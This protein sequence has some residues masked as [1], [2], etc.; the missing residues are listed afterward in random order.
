MIPLTMLGLELRQLF[1]W[2]I[3]AILP[4]VDSAGAFRTRYMDSG[5]YALKYLIARVF[6]ARYLATVE[7]L[8]GAFG[9]II[10]NILFIDAFDDTF[11]D[12]DE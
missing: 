3:Q 6:L 10:A 12:G 5:E 7:S 4:G 2:F 1:K 11:M 8:K 9:P